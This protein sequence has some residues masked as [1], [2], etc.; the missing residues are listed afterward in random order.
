MPEFTVVMRRNVTEEAY[1]DVDAKDEKEAVATAIEQVQ[2][3]VSMGGSTADRPR[4]GSSGCSR[5]RMRI[6]T[7]ASDDERKA[8]GP[9]KTWRAAESSSP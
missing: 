4:S 7:N 5:R 6:P 1:V 2:S 9:A 3:E 8:T